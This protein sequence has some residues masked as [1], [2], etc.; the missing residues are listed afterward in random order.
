MMSLREVSLQSAAFKQYIYKIK[1]Y[2]N[3]VY[4]MFIAQALGLLFSMGGLMSRAFGRNNLSITVKSYSANLVIVFSLFWILITAAT[5]A[6][7]SYRNI[8]FSLVA[9]RLSSNLSNM[10]FLMTFSIFA[11]IMASLSGVL[12]RILGYFIF[13][14]AQVLFEGFLISPIN[15]LFGM[16]VTSLCLILF[17]AIGYLGGTLV[18]LHKS[19]VIIIPILTAGFLKV[20]SQYLMKIYAYFF[21]SSL[22]VFTLKLLALAI[23]L[24][25][26]SI[27]FSNRLEVRK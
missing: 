3:L 14:P 5:I 26:I 16:F 11:G 6:N 13:G 21:E 10:G 27:L 12:L 4:G 9:N 1:G 15:L 22:P 18:E 8:E 20:Y 19:F 7:K 17:S 25:G 2:S 24:F 23:L